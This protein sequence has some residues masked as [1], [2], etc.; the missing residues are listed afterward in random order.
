MNINKN[1]HVII[2]TL[3]N[4][5]H[6]NVNE[7]ESVCRIQNRDTLVNTGKMSARTSSRLFDFWILL[8]DWQH[9][10]LEISRCELH[11]PVISGLSIIDLL[12]QDNINKETILFAGSR[13]CLIR[14]DVI[15]APLCY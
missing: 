8:L 13:L 7:V 5:F 4:V 14:Q 12:N 2:N 6:L 9:A 1:I 10:G 11:K 3:Q 15:G